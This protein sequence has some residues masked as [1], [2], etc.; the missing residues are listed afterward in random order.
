MHNLFLGELR[1][2]CREVWEI[3]IKDKATTRKV[4]AHTPDKQKKWLDKVVSA[5]R[6][7]AAR[8]EVLSSLTQ[9]RKGYLIALA[10]FNDIHLHGKLTKL[11]YAKALLKWV[12]ILAYSERRLAIPPVLSKDTTDFHVKE[13]EYDI[14]KQGI[15]TLNVI[16]HIRA[17]IR[18]TYLP[19]WIER[20]PLNFGSRSHGKLKADHWRTVCTINMVISLVPIWTSSTATEGDRLLLE[21]FIHLVVAVDLATRCTMDAQ[22]ARLFDEHM[23]SYLRTL[24]HLFE[25]QLVPNHHLS[26]HIVTCLLLFRPVHGWW[27]YPFERYNGIIQRLNTNNKIEEIPLTFMRL[28]YAGAELRWL[29]SSTDWPDTEEFRDLMQ[30]FHRVYQDAARGTRVVDVLSEVK[31]SGPSLHEQFK[32]LDDVRLENGLYTQ[33][34]NVINRTRSSEG[35]R[36]PMFTSYD[37][38]LSEDYIRLSPHIHELP[39]FEVDGGVIYGSRDK[40][41][42]NSFILFQDPCSATPSLL[43]AGQISQVFLHRRGLTGNKVVVEPFA[44]VDEY[45]PLSPEH[46]QH[47]PYTRF[48]LLE[49]HLCYNRFKSRRLI[50]RP[51]DISCHFAALVYAPEDIGEPCVVV[52]A[53]DRVSSPSPMHAGES[54]LTVH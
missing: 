40:N 24:R 14:S 44:V 18:A 28:F 31:S 37:S 42:R 7:S 17:D 46:A 26:L 49:T 35:E 10:H 20:P 32:K 48:P 4:T 36:S 22:R 34:V 30:A 51:G 39:K 3:N 27:A 5:L 23:L 33:L 11:E 16:E 47:D 21:N 38:D 41:I 29:V 45:V 53:L 50:I 13:N 6:K 15:I 25:H 52:R 43:C 12:R 54:G 19:S 1:H 9:P 2:H 8:G